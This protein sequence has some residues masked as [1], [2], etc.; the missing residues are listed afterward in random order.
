MT[1]SGF[2]AFFPTSTNPLHPMLPNMRLMN[3]GAPP[4][5]DQNFS[6]FSMP[7]IVPQPPNDDEEVTTSN[8]GASS[9]FSA[10]SMNQMSSDHG[11]E[12]GE[13]NF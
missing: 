9:S 8:H 3:N 5:I 1:A 12:S 7:P 11:N 10:E 4:K 6:P 2:R 13:L